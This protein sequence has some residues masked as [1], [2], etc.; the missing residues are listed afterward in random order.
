M[1]EGLLKAYISAGGDTRQEEIKRLGQ[2]LGSLVAAGFSDDAIKLAVLAR[3]EGGKASTAEIRMASE[4]MVA[5]ADAIK[6]EAVVKQQAL[7]LR[8]A[9]GR[10]T[11]TE[12]ERQNPFLYVERL[13]NIMRRKGLD[14]NDQTAVNKFLAEQS[15]FT[16]SQQRFFAK[17]IPSIEKN[18]RDLGRTNQIDLN[19]TIANPTIA[20]AIADLSA[21]AQD[22]A[23]ALGDATGATNAIKSRLIGLADTLGNISRGNFTGL[24]GAKIAEAL[25]VAVA[26]AFAAKKTLDFFSPMAGAAR[27]LNASAVNLNNAAR[28]LSAAAGRPVPGG[29]GAPGPGS[30]VGGAVGGAVGGIAG[31]FGG[32]AIGEAIGA[33]LGGDAGK[34]VGATIGGAAG[35]ALGIKAGEVAGAALVTALGLPAVGAALATAIAAA[36]VLKPTVA[37]AGED[38][39]IARQREAGTFGQGKMPGSS[40]TEVTKAIGEERLKVEREITAAVVERADSLN[41]IAKLQA[42]LDK[43]REN[44]KRFGLP[45]DPNN[46]RREGEIADERSRV[47]SLDEQLAKFEAAQR[48]LVAEQA[49]AMETAAT[50]SKFAISTSFAEGGTTAA[51]NFNTGVN[52]AGMGSTI[53]STAASEF[54]A[55]VNGLKIGVE[56]K[57]GPDVGA[58]NVHR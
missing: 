48:A 8:D 2:Q 54:M 11:A 39:E 3:D 42:E 15:G 37:N 44:S 43:S 7:G 25:A 13:A 31:G 19:K 55:R 24:D 21:K 12:A 10:S 58:S 4:A 27:N 32:Q 18:L 40:A 49:Q 53:G 45:D 28:A 47:A 35:V 57:T 36:I 46:L 56:L 34:Q 14:P 52:P 6:K 17:N 26:G 38:A 41:R 29:P 30:R 50:N 5:A 22:A 1:A 51:S 20:T 33:Y 9:Q 23:V 16:K